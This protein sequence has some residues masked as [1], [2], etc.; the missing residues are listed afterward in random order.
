MVRRQRRIV[1]LKVHK[2]LMPPPFATRWAIMNEPAAYVRQLTDAYRI[3]YKYWV[4]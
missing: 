1:R 4:R 2:G 3:E